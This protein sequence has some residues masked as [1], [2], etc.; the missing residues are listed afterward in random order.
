ML[1]MKRVGRGVARS[2]VISSRELVLYQ[3]VDNFQHENTNC[4]ACSRVNKRNEIKTS[5]M[6]VVPTA[7]VREYLLQLFVI[8]TL[9]T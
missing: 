6:P 7:A 1:D 9:E 4:A 5:I 8:N 3:R 2:K